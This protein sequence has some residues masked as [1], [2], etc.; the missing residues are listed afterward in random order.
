MNCLSL[1]VYRDATAY[2]FI[3][4]AS[5]GVLCARRIAGAMFFSEYRRDHLQEGN[6]P[7]FMARR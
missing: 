3:C 1:R 2:N 5:S 7:I 4:Y 6:A